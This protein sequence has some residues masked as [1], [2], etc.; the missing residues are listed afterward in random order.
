MVKKYTNVVIGSGIT[1][2]SA[3]FYLGG[4]HILLESKKTCGGA[5]NSVK[6][7]GYHLDM[8]ERFIRMDKEK[9]KYFKDIFGNGFFSKKRLCSQICIG[10]K[11]FGYPFQYN[12]YGMDE[13]KLN[14]CLKEAHKVLSIKKQPRNFK[15]WILLNYG[16]GISDM[17]MTPYNRKIWCVDPSEMSYDWFYNDKVVP[18][19]NFEKM[20]RGSVKSLKEKPVDVDLM[21]RYYP[22]EGGA[23]AVPERI[24]KKLKRKILYG[25]RVIRVDVDKKEVVT[26]KGQRIGYDN[27][28]STI[29]L[30]TLAGMVR[31]SNPSLKSLAKKLKYN[32]V[33]CVWVTVKNIVPEKCHWLYFP[34]SKYPFSRLYF[35]HNFS[36]NIAPKGRS[37]VGAIFTYM[38]SSPD[39]KEVK[40][41]LIAKLIEMKILGSD[42]EVDFVDH[43]KMEF[44]FCIPTVGS[45]AI[46]S[47][48]RL[49]LKKKDIYSI[50]RYGEWKYS[51]ME[52]ALEDGYKI[53]AKLKKEELIR[54]D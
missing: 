48:I 31:P 17:F 34:E 9:E 15:E 38:G 50:G 49:E 36:K 7:N 25:A 18:R 10:D 24:E 46:S 35:Q 47:K 23:S 8:G 19:G 22:K 4:D 2:L 13:K 54:N 14:I 6:K 52:H 1:G 39:V 53:A 44:G 20:V 37:V 41:R 51:G 21:T 3:A 12:L 11:R 16:K 45:S 33:L 28:I 29:P 32:S 5:F 42:K 26:S 43:V 30:N 27:L 40:K